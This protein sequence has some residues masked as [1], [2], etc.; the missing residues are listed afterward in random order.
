MLKEFGPLEWIWEE[1]KAIKAIKFRFR[2]KQ[3]PINYVTV[4][5][6]KMLVRIQHNILFTLLCRKVKG[7]IKYTR[8]FIQVYPLVHAISAGRIFTTFHPNR[9]NELLKY[10]T[11]S[12]LR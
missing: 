1:L 9:I 2:D 3:D 4:L 10:F 7:V 8:D 6:S 5:S 11:P 12:N